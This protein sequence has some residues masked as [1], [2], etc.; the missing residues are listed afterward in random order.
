VADLTRPTLSFCNDIDF[1]DWATYRDVHHVLADQFGIDA[2]DSFWLF[3]PSGGEMALFKADLRQKGPRHE[4]LLEEIRHGRM[5]IL[6]SAGNFSVT[7]TSMR[8]SRGLV[9]E[10]LA[11]LHEHAGVPMVWTNHGDDGDLQNIGGAQP[12]YQQGDDPASD[13]YLIDL[14]LHYG[15]RFF[16]T[17]AGSRNTFVLEAPGQNGRILQRERTR[18]GHC[19][20][21]F[22]RYR[23]LLAK[24]PDAE[25]LWQQLTEEHLGALIA[26][27]G[28]TIVYQHWCVHRDASGRPFT[29]GRPVFPERSLH[30][31]GRLA[32]LR[33]QG[34]L[35]VVPLTNLL[36]TLA[37]EAAPA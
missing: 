16:W 12:V 5:A 30:A 36:E 32:R 25:T 26:A 18:S 20:T 7:N 9:A 22:L 24:A 19:I 33:D 14:A 4:E 6:H 11:Y 34:A 35:D 28:R 17:D 3:D 37:G 27:T 2:Q 8:C 15:V 23:G 10:S 13:T 1:S 31:L 29:A 21:T